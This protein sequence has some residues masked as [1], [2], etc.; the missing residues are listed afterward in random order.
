VNLIVCLEE[1][2]VV[3]LV[4]VLHAFYGT[5][6]FLARNNSSGTLDLEPDISTLNLSLLGCDAV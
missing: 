4:K 5:Q 1:L 6:S 3:Q 2:L